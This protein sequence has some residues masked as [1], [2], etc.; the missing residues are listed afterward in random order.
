MIDL[1]SLQQEL[2]DLHGK[3]TALEAQV[4]F[5][6]KERPGRKMKP[7]VVSKQGVCGINPDCN[8]AECPDASIYRYQQGCQGE[9]CV[10]IN[11]DYYAEYRAKRKANAK[12]TAE[13]VLEDPPA[14]REN[15]EVSHHALDNSAVAAPA[16]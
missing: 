5:L 6:M 12:P 15:G 3:Y 16:S 8:S 13:A 4:E 10:K 11:R 2:S 7:N 1:S 9:L 14:P